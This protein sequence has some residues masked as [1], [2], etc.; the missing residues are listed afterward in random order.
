Y[1]RLRENKLFITPL[2]LLRGEANAIEVVQG[3][4]LHEIGHHL[5]HKGDAAE[6]IWQQADNEGLGRLLNLVADEHLERNLRAKN[7][8]FGDWLNKLAAYAFQH[9]SRQFPVV[10]LLKAL[11]GRAFQTLTRVRLR[12]ARREGCVA[13]SNGD[14]LVEMERAGMSFARFVRALRMGLSNRHA[15]PRVAEALALVRDNFRQA[16]MGRL[17]ELARPRREVIGDERQILVQLGQHH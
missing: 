12:V 4:I 9:T 6:A 11:K 8:Q 17:A 2:P 13:V 14:L 1:T 10:D 16:K 5:Y 3:L 7:Q 15:D